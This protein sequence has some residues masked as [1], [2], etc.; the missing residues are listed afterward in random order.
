MEWMQILQNRRS[1]RS[2]TG[3]DIPEETLKQILQAGLLAPSGRGVRPWQFVVV[4]D[5]GTLEQMARCRTAGAGMLAGAAAAV[6]VLGDESLTDVW[7]ED[8][9]IAMTCMHLTADALGVG[10]CW[11]QGRLRTGPDGRLAEEALR[12]LL[13][14]PEHLR[15]EAVLSLGMPA[16]RPAPHT[17]EELDWSKVHRETF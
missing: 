12:E 17:L 8:C 7:V 9:S 6:V 1:I 16:D 13:G 10:S 5:R 15:L 2:Y 14:Y 4:R 3:E 11:V